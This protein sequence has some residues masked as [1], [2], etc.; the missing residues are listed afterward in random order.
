MNVIIAVGVFLTLVLLIEAVYLGIRV[1]HNPEQR[2]TRERL[3]R[4]AEGDSL[5]ILRRNELSEVPW[6]NRMLMGIGRLRNLDLVLKQA[7]IQYPLGFFILF[8]LLVASIAFWVGRLLSGDIWSGLI[9]GGVAGAIPFMYIFRKRTQRM[10]RFQAQ[11]PDS[12]EMMGRALKAGHAFSGA[13]KMVA[14]EFDD[15][16]GLELSKVVSEI[17]F[18][19]SLPE[20][21]KNLTDRVD[22]PDLRYFVTSVLVQRETGGNLTEI[23]DKIAH[24]IRE[25]VKLHGKIRVL[26]AEG[27][28]SAYI[29]I[30]LPFFIAGAV[31]IMSP[32]YL[33]PLFT[34]PMGKKLVAVAIVM[35]LLGI[36]IIRKLT[37]IK[38]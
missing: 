13:L 4:F 17:N 19:I 16:M 34:D 28:F 15:P 21:L 12:L 6:F 3:R 20:A 10:N 18:G 14:D 25:R 33:R 31:Y 27:K 29:L 23:L 37:Q 8:A 24:L 7:D 9:I 1:V 2:K 5:N 35:M 36:F 26:A 38:V 32:E 11:L 22:C 30:G